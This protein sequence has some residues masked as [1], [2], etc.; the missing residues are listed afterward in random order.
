MTHLQQTCA[1]MVSSQETLQSLFKVRRAQLAGKWDTSREAAL[2]IEL[3]TE[4][5]RN[6]IGVCAKCL[7]R[8]PAANDATTLPGA[9]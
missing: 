9:A 7:Q 2:R 3:A 4:T 5:H 6:F 8:H 1:D